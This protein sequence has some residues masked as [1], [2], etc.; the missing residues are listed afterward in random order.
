[1]LMFR[2]ILIAV[3]ES[4]PTG[5]VVEAGATLARRLEARVALVHVVDPRL[6]AAPEPGIPLPEL[7]T[8]LEKAG[9]EFLRQLRDRLLA[10]LEA[11]LFVRDGRPADEILA[12]AREW[13]ADLIVIGTHEHSGLQRLLMS[14]TTTSVVDHAPCPVLTV[15]TRSGAT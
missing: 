7:L 13:G 11:E 1:M 5:R 3:D 9:Q 15:P 6:D 4:E 12:V 14:S 8:D 10:S 2:R